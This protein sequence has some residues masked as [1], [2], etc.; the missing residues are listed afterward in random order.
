MVRVD[1]LFLP[2]AESE[3]ERLDQALSA[4][5]KLV[6][7]ICSTQRAEHTRAPPGLCWR[8]SQCT[9]GLP[10]KREARMFPFPRRPPI[11]R[12]PAADARCAALCLD[13]GAGGEAAKRA[14]C[15]RRPSRALAFAFRPPAVTLAG[16]GARAHARRRRGTRRA[17]R[18][19]AH[20]R[21]GHVQRRPPLSL[22]GRGRHK[23]QP[24]PSASLTPVPGGAPQRSS[25]LARSSVAAD[26]QAPRDRALR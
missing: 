9:A 21:T 22:A 18:D 6:R 19:R 20:R 7:D 26:R 23:L 10:F 8:L 17:A 14:Q 16:D 13:H 3:L 25:R 2:C 15:A 24:R 1:R 4:G 12:R 5:F 11:Q